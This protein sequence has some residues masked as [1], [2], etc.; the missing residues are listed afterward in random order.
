MLG[1]SSLYYFLKA[2]M[3]PLIFAFCIAAFALFFMRKDKKSRKGKAL[4]VFSFLFL[5][6]S[7]ISPVADMMCY[8]VER[9]YL[10]EERGNYKRLDVVVVLGGG[11]NNK[12]YAREVMPSNQT[13]ARLLHA[14]QV[15][16]ISGAEYLVCSARGFG[17]ITEAEVMK[18]VAE[19][20]GVPA[21]KIKLDN[22]SDNTKQH[23]EELNKLFKDKNITIGLVTS[24]Y[25][26][27]RSEREFSKYFPNVIPFPSDYLYSSPPLSIMTF[28]PSSENLYKFSTVFREM[29][30]IAWYKVKG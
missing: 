12:G 10:T 13:A 23:A 27:K 26:M 9:E 6:L 22:K 24:A 28:I 1:M 21:Q 30:G 20:L 25:H 18:S 7:S 11:I 14:V 8:L 3:D 29:I 16:N 2:L 5:Y 4:L 19:G 15:F 17:N